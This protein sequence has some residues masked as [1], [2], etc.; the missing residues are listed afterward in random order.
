LW[1]ATFVRPQREHRA[2]PLS[3]ACG[4]KFFDLMKLVRG[5]DVS[6]ALFE[7]LLGASHGPHPMPSAAIALARDLEPNGP[8]ASGSNNGS[9]GTA[10][11][12]RSNCAWAMRCP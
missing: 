4:N 1:R 3:P 5:D 7:C 12:T 6:A 2:W 11:P 10:A 9:A 8:G